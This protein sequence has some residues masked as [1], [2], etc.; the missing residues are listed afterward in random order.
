L[1]SI[2][3]LLEETGRSIS[4][5]AA[6]MTPVVEDIPVF[7][8]SKITGDVVASNMEMQTTESSDSVQGASEA[9]KAVRKGRKG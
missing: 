5:T 3:E 4:P 2:R 1:Q 9:L 6:T 8:P 7:I